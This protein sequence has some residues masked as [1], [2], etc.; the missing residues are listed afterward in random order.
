MQLDFWS[1]LALY[2]NGEA[3]PEQQLLLFDLL[4]QNAEY[5]EHFVAA[6]L[7]WNAPKAKKQT[8]S[9]KKLKFLISKDSVG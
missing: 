3:S 1:L 7:I 4:E 8:F 6:K 5:M 2:L 9:G